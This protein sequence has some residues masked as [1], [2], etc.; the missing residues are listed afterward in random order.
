MSKFGSPSSAFTIED[1]WLSKFGNK[2]LHLGCSRI[3]VTAL[4][5]FF[6]AVFH[7]SA[8]QFQFH[9][10]KIVSCLKL[11]NKILHLGSS[12]IEI[13]ALRIFFKRPI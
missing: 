10:R 8:S 1:C 6:K 13:T 3:E 12:C 7:V 11:G 9:N 2:I 4:T 5:I